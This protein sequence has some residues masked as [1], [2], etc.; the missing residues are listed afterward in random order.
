MILRVIIVLNKRTKAPPYETGIQR[1]CCRC[2]GAKRQEEN[3]LLR[4]GY[5]EDEINSLL[6]ECNIGYGCGNGA[7]IASINPGESVL[8]LGSGGGFDCFLARGQTGSQGHVIG[9]DMVPAMVR[10]SRSNLKKSGYTNV[11][12]R[13]GEIEHLPVADETI[14]AV[15]SNCVLGLSFDKPQVLREAHRVLKP[16]GRVSLCDFFLIAPMPQRIRLELNE[17][18]CCLENAITVEQLQLFLRQSGFADIR[19][20][21]EQSAC[22]QCLPCKEAQAYIAPYCVQAFKG[23]PYAKGS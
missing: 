7:S 11:E 2:F 23:D 18:F 6:S 8:D 5:T 4:F 16:G 10:L 20:R 3:A 21:Q 1:R 22:L 9:V 17:Y 19:S 15:L 12:F 14:D 13:L